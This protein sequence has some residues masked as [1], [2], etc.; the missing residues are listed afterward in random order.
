MKK[1]IYGFLIFSV[2]ILAIAPAVNVKNELNTGKKVID[3][4]KSKMSEWVDLS[5]F[6][7]VDFA[8]PALSYT[9]YKMGISLYPND[10]VVGKGGWLFLGDKY[11][12]TL[13]ENRN[14][15]NDIRS[16]IDKMKN[17]RIAWDNY[18]RNHG[19]KG[20][21]VS[22]AP[23]K[24]SV[25]PEFVPNWA[26][27]DGGSRNTKY[28]LSSSKSDHTFINM[29]VSFDEL[30]KTGPIYYRTDSHWNVRGA[31]AGYKELA[32]NISIQIPSIKWLKDKDIIITKSKRNGG[33]LSRFLRLQSSLMDSE[34]S[35]SVPGAKIVKIYSWHGVFQKDLPINNSTINRYT[36]QETRN[37]SA[38]NRLRVLWLT[39][40]FGYGL[41]PFM[42]ATFSNIFQV[43]YQKA[44]A[45]PQIMTGVISTYKPDLV[46]VTAV[47]RQAMSIPLF[48]NIPK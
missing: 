41:E 26:A 32:K 20:Y 39:D 30:K 2:A 3:T 8:I 23:D 1:Y 37:D 33:D 38:M 35:A 5:S 16:Q 27:G 15:S 24:H 36:P 34:F 48:T 14:V 28:L 31:W 18:V 45:T 12:K 46:I 4:S 44:L 29:G 43:H 13:S 9:L 47:E 22:F 25:Y 6:Y 7:K 19:G 10:T 42:N 17:A 40:S 11:S 21:F